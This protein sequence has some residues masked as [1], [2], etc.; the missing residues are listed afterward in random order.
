MTVA[1]S[2]SIS[3]LRGRILAMVMRTWSWPSAAFAGVCTS[4]R[5]ERP[6]RGRGRR[7]LRAGGETIYQEGA[8]DG[9][10]SG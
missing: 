6:A 3:T 2:T 5:H 1:V 10:G 8:Q 9:V 7:A 4:R